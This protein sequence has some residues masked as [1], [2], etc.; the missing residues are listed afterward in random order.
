M[1]NKLIVI[2]LVLLMLVPSVVA[3]INY[4]SESSGS[5]NEGNTLSV[6]FSD[7]A[8]SKDHL[9]NIQC[10]LIEPLS[11]K[12]L[13]ENCSGAFVMLDAAAGSSRQDSAQCKT[14]LYLQ[15]NSHSS[16]DSHPQ[17]YCGSAN[18]AEN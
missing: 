17:L 12:L 14:G 10:T 13:Q 3:I 4:S 5:V 8:D 11:N 2:I 6:S 18:A 15:I 1:K 7:I 9:Y 16:A